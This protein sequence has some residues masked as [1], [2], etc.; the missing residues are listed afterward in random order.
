MDSRGKMGSH[1]ESTWLDKAHKWN[2]TSQ[3]RFR[4]S[5]DPIVTFMRPHPRHS[6]LV[7]N[8]CVLQVI[9]QHRLSGQSYESGVSSRQSYHSTSSSSLGSLDRL[10]ESG[11][12][13]TINVQQ[14]IQAG[15][16]VST[17]TGSSPTVINQIY[18]FSFVVSRFGLAGKVLGC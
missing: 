11:H 12:T 3:R 9:G 2:T 10:E 13:S 8:A 5:Q 6:I 1:I 17:D 7:R 16:P 14:L 15:V 4:Y 18:V